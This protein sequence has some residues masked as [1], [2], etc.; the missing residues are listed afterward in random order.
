VIHYKS[1]YL[2]DGDGRRLTF[3]FDRARGEFLRDD[4]GE[5]VPDPRGL[6]FRQWRDHI[7]SPADIWEEIVAAADMP[8]VTSAPKLQ[9]IE[10]RLVMLQTGM[11]AAMGLKIRAPDLESL[12]RATREL[13]AALREVPAIREAT[14]SADRV[15]GKPYLEIVPDREA[16]ARHGL[17]MEQVQRVVAAAIG[18]EQVTTTVEGRQRYPVRV[19][20]HRE[21]RQDIDDMEQVLIAT[22]EGGHVPLSQVAEIEY[23][24]G[25]QMIRSEDTFL[26][27]YVTFGAEPGWAEV[28]VVEAARAY[29]DEQLASGTLSVP[30]GVSWRFAGNYEHQV[31]AARTLAIVLP[32]ALMLIFLILY[33]QFRSA[34]TAGI[35][36]TDV[37]IAWAGGF[38]MIYLF[39]QPWFGDVSLFGENM[40]ELFNLQPLNL[41]VA[42][43]VGF[44]ALFGIAVDN[45]VVVATYMEQTFRRER[46]ETVEA[47]REAVVRAGERRLRPCLITTATTLLALLPVLT[48]TGR[49]SDIMIPMAIPSLG[50]MLFVLLTLVSV[51]VLYALAHER[52]WLRPTTDE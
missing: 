17:T 45:A 51:P 15:V 12:E 47:I 38:A 29:L 20:Y 52:G 36:F 23:R 24:R 30:P 49:G 16:I 28:E 42:V 18:G 39:G 26:T 34:L 41:S 6:P 32:V 4:D 37:A 46:P 14:L 31:R 7:R 25:P 8:G 44:L 1:E 21:K 22:R 9:P 50:G 10:T 3:A 40:R 48:S 11:R 5:L 33:L 19:R 13:E 2:T 27:S 35:V 43:W